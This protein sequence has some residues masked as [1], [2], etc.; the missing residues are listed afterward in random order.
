M[1][2]LVAAGAALVARVLIVRGRGRRARA[3]RD[4]AR[5]LRVRVKGGYVPDRVVVRAGVPVRLIFHREETAPCSESVVFPD[6]GTSVML[7]PHR[8]VAVD[9]PASE[10][11]E[12]EFTC[13]MGML[14]GRV[15]VIA[16]DGES[17][18][19]PTRT[20]GRAPA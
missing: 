15:I 20:N 12:H 16:A 2:W 1:E 14:R 7:P 3:A 9:L 13:H 19:A 5:E 10:P 6:F 8:D 18:P 11:G 4:G 17:S